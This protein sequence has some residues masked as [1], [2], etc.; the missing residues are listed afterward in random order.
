MKKIQLASPEIAFQIPGLNLPAKIGQKEVAITPNQ[1]MGVAVFKE[2]AQEIVS[3][4]KE[5][6]DLKRELQVFREDLE[7]KND[8]IA[9]QS[10][11][12]SN[13]QRQ[14]WKSVE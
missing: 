6:A 12:I 13:L 5:N 11:E 4:R 3:L 7:S 2:M 10:A 14:S 9:K 1:V 8:Q